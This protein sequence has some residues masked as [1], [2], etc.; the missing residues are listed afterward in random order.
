MSKRE[1]SEYITKEDGSTANLNAA[2]IK[3]S[4]ATAAQLA[5]RK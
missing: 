5:K 4:M 2:E 3:P 1:A